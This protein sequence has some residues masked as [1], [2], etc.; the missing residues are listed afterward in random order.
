MCSRSLRLSLSN[1]VAAWNRDVENS[2]QSWNNSVLKCGTQ[3]PML[4]IFILQKYVSVFCWCYFR[5]YCLFRFWQY[6]K[7]LEKTKRYKPFNVLP[8]SKSTLCGYD[9]PHSGKMM[10]KCFP[11]LPVPYV[12]PTECKLL[13]HP[14]RMVQSLTHFPSGQN[15]S[16][17]LY[18][19][20]LAVPCCQRLV[21]TFHR[22][23][24]LANI[25]SKVLLFLCAFSIW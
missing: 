7:D 24:A 14:L 12:G 19:A 3:K 5:L 13:F 1:V 9:F 17:R 20:N 25:E 16:D 8:W 21:P 2:Y 23:A 4:S 22:C 18:S 11:L 15:S 6:F 10:K